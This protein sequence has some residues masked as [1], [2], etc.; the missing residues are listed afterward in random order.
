MQTG[1]LPSQTRALDSVVPDILPSSVMCK[2]YVVKMQEGLRLLNVQPSRLLCVVPFDSTYD[3]HGKR[4]ILMTP[5]T[6]CNFDKPLL[7]QRDL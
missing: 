7:T 1:I 4:N 5:R 2:V 3:K 6:S